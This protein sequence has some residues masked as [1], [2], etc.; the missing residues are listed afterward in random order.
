[1]TGMIGHLIVALEVGFRAVCC[2]WG[3][4]VVDYVPTSYD[5]NLYENNLTLAWMKHISLQVLTSRNH[6]CVNV[7]AIDGCVVSL[8]LTCS[9]R[10]S[11]LTLNR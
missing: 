9:V 2:F 6:T 3:M 1:M 7:I 8:G 5:P 4:Y 10:C 11:E